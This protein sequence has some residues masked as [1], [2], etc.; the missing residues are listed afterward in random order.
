MTVVPHNV[1]GIGQRYM[2]PYRNVVAIMI[3][4]MKQGKP[5]V[6]YG[7]GTQ[8]RSF[9]NIMDCVD[10]VE[11]IVNTDR[12]LCGEVYNIGP[13]DNEIEIKDIAFKIGQVC[14]KYPQFKHFPDRPTE[15]KDAWCSSEKIRKD[16]NYNAAVPLEQTIKEMCMWIDR[17]GIEEF[18]YSIDLEFVTDDTPKTWVERLI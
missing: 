15:V 17:R 16:F 11:K 14:E 10:A 1:I 13:D 7:D 8:K 2:D 6:I 3:N 9:S 4:R 5:I 18:D 12:D